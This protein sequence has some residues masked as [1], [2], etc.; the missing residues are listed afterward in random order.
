MQVLDYLLPEMENKRGSLV[1]VFSGYK[2]QMDM[3]MA[4]NEGLPGRFPFIYTFTDFTDD[5]LHEILE[6]VIASDNPVFKL[7]DKKYARIA[8]RR[9]G[10]MRGMVGFGNARAVRIMYE[11]ILTKQ[12]DRIIAQRE[13]GL[14]PNIM[15]L[16]RDDMLGP[17]HIN[18]DSSAAIQELLSMRGLDS[19]KASVKTLLLVVSANAER[20][21][22]EKQPWD[23]CL[24]RVFLGNPGTGR[25]CRG[26]VATKLLTKIYTGLD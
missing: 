8:S 12:A 2:N 9:L 1:V 13:R 6:G 25:Y 14:D 15:M 23:V 17:M 3:L 4:Y 11:G 5:E 10:R 22:L 21:E 26:L 24:N 19:V 16:E 7:Q 20:E 18:P